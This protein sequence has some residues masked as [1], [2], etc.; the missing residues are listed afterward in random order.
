VE[1]VR[2][3]MTGVVPAGIALHLAVLAG[4]AIAGFYAALVLTRRRLLT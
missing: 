4:Y 3:L 1:L 2:P